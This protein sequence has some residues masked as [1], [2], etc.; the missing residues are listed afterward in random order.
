[1][2]DVMPASTLLAI[3]LPPLGLVIAIVLIYIYRTEED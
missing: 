3:G 2:A 1:M